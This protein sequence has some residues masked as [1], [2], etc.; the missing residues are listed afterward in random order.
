MSTKPWWGLEHYARPRGSLLSWT[1]GAV[2]DY[3]ATRG[4]TSDPEK[5]TCKRCLAWLAKE[6][7]DENPACLRERAQ[8]R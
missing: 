5:V 3:R 1:G 4:L 6:D 7:Q 8:S 2:C